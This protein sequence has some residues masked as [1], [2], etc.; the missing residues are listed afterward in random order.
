MPRTKSSYLTHITRLL[1]DEIQTGIDAVFVN[2]SLLIQVE[3]PVI[4]IEMHVDT[5]PLK[6]P[7]LKFGLNR[8]I[9]PRDCMY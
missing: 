2:Q 6:I 1:R 9:F 4:F 7:G 8:M 5:E 3:D